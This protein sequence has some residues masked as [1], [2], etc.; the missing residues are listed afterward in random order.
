VQLC[1]PLQHLDGA[2]HRHKWSIVDS[3]NGLGGC[4][5]RDRDAVLVWCD[6]RQG[7]HH[8]TEVIVQ[9]PG[10]N[11]TRFI[12]C[13]D[14]F[15]STHCGHQQIVGN[16]SKLVEHNVEVDFAHSARKQSHWRTPRRVGQFD[17][18]GKFFR[19][20]QLVD[21]YPPE[22]VGFYD[23][24]TEL[25]AAIQQPYWHDSCGMEHSDVAVN[26]FFRLKSPE[27]D[28]PQCVEYAI[29]NDQTSALT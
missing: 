3:K 5:V 9:Q 1:A 11:V 6:V 27:R 23:T 13:V 26:C 24:A 21:W 4:P 10:W 15:D 18:I 19:V 25:D 12:E 2:V 22:H 7:G 17:K 28:N 29:G 16:T 8:G 20:L 14:E